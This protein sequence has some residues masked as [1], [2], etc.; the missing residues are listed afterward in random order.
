MLVRATPDHV[1]RLLRCV[2]ERRS[3]HIPQPAKR[4]VS[5]QSAIEQ[6]PRDPF[7]Q[8]VIA[9]MGHGTANLF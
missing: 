8:F 4:G 1:R 7:P 6:F 5:L 2:C 9:A 3:R